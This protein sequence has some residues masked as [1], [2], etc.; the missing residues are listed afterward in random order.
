MPIVYPP[1]STPSFFSAL[2]VFVASKTRRR[3]F[4]DVIEEKYALSFS[5]ICSCFSNSFSTFSLDYESELEVIEAKR[6]LT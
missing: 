3:A 5:P 6:S 1:T 4:F 2:S